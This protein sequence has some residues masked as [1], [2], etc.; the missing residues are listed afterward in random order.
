MLF[1]SELKN[2]PL[3][4]GPKPTKRVPITAG[5]EVFQLKK[6]GQILTI[7]VYERNQLLFR[8]FTDGKN[9]I[10][11]V[12]QLN[13]SFEP[14]SWIKRNPFRE[15]LSW[16]A[17]IRTSENV[18][19]KISTVIQGAPQIV[20]SDDYISRVVSSFIYDWHW[21]KKQREQEAKAALMEKHME[22]LPRYPAGLGKFCEDHVFHESIVYLSKL[23][24]GKRLGVCRHCGKSFALGRSVKPGSEGVCPKCG[25]P[26]RF[27]GEWTKGKVQNK[28]KIC[29]TQKVDG[30]M[31]L[32]YVDVVRTILA[33]D[34]KPA[35]D[36]SDYFIN[37]FPSGT[38][39]GKCYAYYWKQ[40]PYY[41]SGWKRL[42]NGAKCFGE[43][44]V[45]TENLRENFGGHY[46]NVD[47]AAGLSILHRPLD[48][49][50]YWTTY[51]LF[52]KPST[53]SRRGCPSL[54]QTMLC[55]Q[56]TRVASQNCW[57]SAS[58]TFRYCVRCRR[59]GQRSRPSPQQDAGFRR[60]HSGSCAH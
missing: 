60:T 48:F 23:V 51:G 31:V 40:W 25:V 11:W 56:I 49:R 28:A 9:Y 5:V 19:K 30:Q 37:I 47:L 39:T 59:I 3:T 55:G 32:R 17:N 52:H 13:G 10:T 44:Y 21:Q 43:T 35:Y 7:D 22:M 29:V 57:A 58:N 6:S 8:Y 41:C 14:Q 26:V 33:D 2:L 45:Y 24:K 46:H 18:G 16:Y 54:R 50:N 27:R 42:Q 4:A 1:K 15:V 20:S 36:F 38:L 34:R 12:E 53:Y